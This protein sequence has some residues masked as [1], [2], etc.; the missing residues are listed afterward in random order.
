MKWM[1]REGESSQTNNLRSACTRDLKEERVESGSQSA[2]APLNAC[3]PAQGQE[4]GTNGHCDN[5]N[6]VSIK[7]LTFFCKFGCVHS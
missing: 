5:N 3:L 6:S 1:A 2:A 7:T 4:E